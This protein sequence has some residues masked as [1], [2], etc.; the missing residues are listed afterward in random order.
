MTT[1]SDRSPVRTLPTRTAAAPSSGLRVFLEHSRRRVVPSRTVLVSAGEAPEI[2]FHVVSGSVEVLI[3][4]EEGN[5]M[6]LAYLSK[7][8]FFGEIAVLK[9][10]RRNATVRATARTQ[11]LVLDSGDLRSLMTQRPDIAMRIHEVAQNRASR[12]TTVMSTDVFRSG[13]EDGEG[14]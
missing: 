8:Q 13:D 4:D 7:G 1:P 14:D 6:V 12:T 11:L 10:T 2:L 5:E 3:E 9:N